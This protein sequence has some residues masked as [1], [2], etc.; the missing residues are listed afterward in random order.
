MPECCGDKE[1]N[2]VFFWLQEI[3]ISRKKINGAPKLKRA[4][5]LSIAAEENN[6]VKNLFMSVVVSVLE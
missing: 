2:N 1:V 6:L 3:R 5:D 4:M